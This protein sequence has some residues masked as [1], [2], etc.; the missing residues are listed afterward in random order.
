MNNL[1]NFKGNEVEI[2]EYKGEILFNPRD[3]A[4]CIGITESTLR[5]HISKF[6]KTQVIKLKNKDILDVGL[7]DF[8]KLN[9]AG[10]NFLK[11]PGLYKLIFKSEKPEAEEF[12]D[13]VTDSV[14]PTLRQTGGYVIEDREEEFVF[15]YFPSFSDDV[16]LA[17]VDDLIKQNKSL[18][19]NAD[20]YKNFMS[21]DETFAFRELVKH[22]NGL[23]LNLKENQVRNKLKDDGII[24]KQGKKYVITEEGVRDGYGVIKDVIINEQNRPVTR[25]TEKLRDY[26]LEEFKNIG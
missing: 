17:M 8:R 9:N 12:Q 23:G 25:Y 14:L 16:K 18:K 7:I 20:K 6:T 13:W 1:F 15:K 21:T 5:D 3:I 11:E 10:E 24:C 2:F 4:K 26:L 19:V 22:L